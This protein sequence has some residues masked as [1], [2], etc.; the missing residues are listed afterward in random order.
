MH[1]CHVRVR[2]QSNRYLDE[3]LA[4][5]AKSPPAAHPAS[6]W[7]TS[8]LLGRCGFSVTAFGSPAVY[9]AL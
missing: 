2:T 3:L 9:D 8:Q 7:L 5:F 6:P 4:F 1:A